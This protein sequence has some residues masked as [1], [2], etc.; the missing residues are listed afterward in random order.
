MSLIE[1]CTV[2]RVWIPFR[3]TERYLLLDIGLEQRRQLV[4]LVETLT[5][6]EALAPVNT[7]LE[8]LTLNFFP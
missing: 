5:S 2:R 4:P 6:H 3:G 1:I 7:K 8:D